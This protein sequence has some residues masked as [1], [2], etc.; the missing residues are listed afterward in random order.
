MAFTEHSGLALSRIRSR[1]LVT[2]QGD[3]SPEV[4]ERLRTELLEAVRRHRIRTLIV[5]LSAVQ[6][7]DLS[8]VNMLQQTAQM[9]GLMGART[10]LIGLSAGITRCLSPSAVRKDHGTPNSSRVWPRPVD[11]SQPSC[12]AN[13]MI[14]ISP[15][16]K[17]GSE[18]PRM[19]PAMM[20]RAENEFGRRPA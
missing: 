16:Q 6:L 10:C 2:L 12:T 18:K 15:T 3:L 19:E 11:G 17:V 9:A 13:T 1:L 8:D 7:M 14:S 20:L 4:H 5:D